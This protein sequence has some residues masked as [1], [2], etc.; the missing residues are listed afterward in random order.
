MFGLGPAEIAVIAG[1]AFL[2][3]GPRVV[4]RFTK[5]AVRTIQEGRKVASELMEAKD[6][7][8]K[9]ESEKETRNV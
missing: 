9:P 4:S 8:Q 7:N 6:G 5:T 2:L 1:I 3:F